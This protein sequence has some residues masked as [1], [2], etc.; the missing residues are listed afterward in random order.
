[1]N[2]TTVREVLDAYFERHPHARSYILDDQGRCGGTWRYS[3]AA[4]PCAT[5]PG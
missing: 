3:S 5:A 4:S 2:G 1:M